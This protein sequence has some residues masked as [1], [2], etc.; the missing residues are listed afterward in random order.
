MLFT[1]PSQYWF[2]IGLSGVFSLTGWSPLIHTEF[3]VFRATQDT[4]RLRP[5]FVYGIFTLYDHIFQCVPL[6]EFLATTWSYNPNIA[7]TTLVW[8]V[9]RSL[10]TTSG[11]TFVFFSY[12]YLDVSVPHVRFPYGMTGLQPDGLPHSEIQGSKSICVSPQLIA[13]YHVLHRLREPRHPPSALAYFLY[14]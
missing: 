8:A 2:T 11:I 6:P 7:S 10:A 13:A 3:L 14:H 1:F 4:T 9:P 5:R 12:G